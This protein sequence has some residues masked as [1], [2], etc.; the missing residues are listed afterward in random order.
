MSK[1]IAYSSR[2]LLLI[3]LAFLSAGYAKADSDKLIIISPHWEGIETEF[4]NAFKEFYKN[5]TGRDVILKW[6][7]QGGTSSDFRYVRSQFE[8]LR[9]KDA[10]PVNGIGIDLFFGGGTDIYLKMAEKGWL[11]PY[12]LNE[13]QLDKVPQNIFG[14]PIYD[15][16]YR[17]YGVVLSTF[18]IM[19]NKMLRKRLRLPE[20]KRWMDLTN[21]RLIKRVSMADPRESGSAHKIY[22]IILQG[23]GWNKGFQVL[24][25]I[26]GNVKS[27]PAGSN[28]IPKEVVTGTVLFGTVIDFYAFKQVTDIGKDKVG[29]IIPEDAVV[30]GADPIAILKGAPNLKVA[31]RFMDFVFSDKGQK[32]WMLPKGDAEGPSEFSLQRASV[33]P[34]LYKELGERS[35][36]PINPFDIDT[37][38]LEYDSEKGS[39]RWNIVNDL[40]GAMIIDSHKE[41]VDAWMAIRK[42]K[43]KKAAIEE[44]G[45]LPVTEDEALKLAEKWDDQAFRNKKI[46]EWTNFAREKYDRAKELAK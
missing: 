39:A 21:P 24:T 38:I 12:E 20:V 31:E 11:R 16:E 19:E 34:H 6:L 17:W 45:K 13:K 1:K 7:D 30:I 5:E 22:E 44:L 35:V 25:E 8:K 18:V 32:L 27:F 10:E 33:M 3:L 15:N 46:S 23:H 28:Q 14:I 43:N 4:E 2:A 36:I 37:G 9:S 29:S 42:S 26:G 41:L 40:I